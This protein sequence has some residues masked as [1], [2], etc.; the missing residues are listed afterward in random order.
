L[1]SSVHSILPTFLSSLE[2]VQLDSPVRNCDPY[3]FKNLKA[4]NFPPNLEEYIYYP[5]DLKSTTFVPWEHNES[6][7]YFDSLERY[8]AE[9]DVVM[10]ILKSLM[11]RRGLKTSDKPRFKYNFLIVP[12]MRERR[13]PRSIKRWFITYRK[14]R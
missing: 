3:A 12:P 7:H 2:I 8:E 4:M 5:D 14:K 1:S 10:L 11:K 13:D 6:S 9:P